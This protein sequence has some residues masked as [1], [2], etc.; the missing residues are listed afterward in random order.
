[1]N[2]EEFIETLFNP[3]TSTISRDLKL[4]LSR[5]LTNGALSNQE[6][7]L[8]L[9]ALSTSLRCEAIKSYARTALAEMGTEEA[10]IQEAQES[11]AMMAML[12]L[13]YRF[14]HLLTH[15]REE[16]KAEYQPANLRMTALAKPVLGKVNFEM[17]AF[18]VSVLGGCE[19]CIQ[20]HEAVLREA[21][22][23][24]NKIHDLARLAAVVGGIS[25]LLSI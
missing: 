19:S 18:A 13:Y 4:N 6:A 7:H 23:E 10:H 24:V 22:I 8:A 14:R 3:F 17:L 9:L 25:T 2:T 21:K 1:M 5:L 15:D 16:L 11:A 12:N 20:S